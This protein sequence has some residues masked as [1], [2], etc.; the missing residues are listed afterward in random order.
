[1]ERMGARATLP[2]R[3]GTI[4]ADGHAGVGD[5]TLRHMVVVATVAAC[6]AA[7]AALLS[8]PVTLFSWETTAPA[9]V[10]GPTGTPTGMGGG[11]HRRSTADGGWPPTS[12][13][14]TQPGGPPVLRPPAHRA[15]APPTP[16]HRVP[17][18]R[19]TRRECRLT[20]WS[21]CRGHTFSLSTDI[22]VPR[23]RMA[24]SSLARGVCGRSHRHRPAGLMHHPVRES[25]GP[26]R[27][28]RTGSAQPVLTKGHAPWRDPCAA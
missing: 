28:R 16:T 25:G 12:S 9:S 21:H 20:A 1:M 19:G 17:S 18:P 10:D 27:A 23:R 22:T 4:G 6:T 3:K 5:M 8:T 15:S 13:A 24:P 11:G 7:T 2:R 26:G 14:L